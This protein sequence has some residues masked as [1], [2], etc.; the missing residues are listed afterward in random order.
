MSKKKRTRT[1][2]P[3]KSA[4]TEPLTRESGGPIQKRAERKLDAILATAADLMARHG[5]D[6][7]SI[8]DVAKRTG[9][10]LAGMYYYF[11]S[12]EEL[13]FQIQYHTFASLLAEQEKALAEDRAP[14]DQL[15][16]LVQNH[17]AFFSDR[18]SELKVC[19]FE[20]ESLEGAQFQAVEKIRRRYFKIAAEVV[21]K[22][23]GRTSRRAADRLAVRHAT[24]FIFAMLN[25]IYM[26][27]E[28]DRDGPVSQLGK[29]MMHFILDGLKKNGRSR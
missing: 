17:L 24:L 15:R 16:S 5:Y 8:R 20:L 3:L 2:R 11:D 1:G 22:V 21:G 26:W 23:M 14:E 6:K 25:W 19:G 13:L 18:P 7:T 10:S 9:C 29:E 12:K 27:Y 4:V 28:P